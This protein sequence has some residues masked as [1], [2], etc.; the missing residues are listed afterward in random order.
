MSTL[1]DCAYNDF[2]EQVLKNLYK[3]VHQKT[4]Q[5]NQ[6]GILKICSRVTWGGRIKRND[7]HTAWTYLK[8][9][10]LGEKKKP[11]FKDDVLCKSY[12]IFEITKL[13]YREGKQFS[14]CQGLGMVGEGVSVTLK[15]FSDP[16]TWVVS[17]FI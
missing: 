10:M 2:L 6:S 7:T 16:L 9:I 14:G 1:V 8:S 12:N 17:P 15:E 5:I 4:L 3:E 11:V 13:C